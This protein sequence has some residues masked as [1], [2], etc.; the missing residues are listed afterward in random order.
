MNITCIL[1]ERQLNV[2]CFV[3]LSNLCLVCRQP[4]PLVW[5]NIQ[6]P[7]VN[8]DE[9]VELFSKGSVKEKKKPIS[10]TISRSKANQVDCARLHFSKSVQ[11]TQFHISVDS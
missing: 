2:T 3:L 6:E 4:S 11:E 7:T 9:F 1:I 5:E 8:F 10:D